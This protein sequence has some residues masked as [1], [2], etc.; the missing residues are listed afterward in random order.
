MQ[1]FSIKNQDLLYFAS[2]HRGFQSTIAAKAN[3]LLGK[4]PSVAFS[5]NAQG[6][7]IVNGQD[8]LISTMHVHAANN[9]YGPATPEEKAVAQAIEQ[10][11]SNFK[12]QGSGALIQPKTQPKGPPLNGLFQRA[13]IRL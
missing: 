3:T 8:I 9:P 11:V 12:S 7:V 5:S 4:S 10:T 2:N 6:G 1:P 13:R